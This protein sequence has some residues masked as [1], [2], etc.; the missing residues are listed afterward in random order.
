MMIYLLISVIIVLL[1]LLLLY[2]LDTQCVITLVIR[3]ITMMDPFFSIVTI[4]NELWN[5]SAI[6][7][8]WCTYTNSPSN[9]LNVI[10]H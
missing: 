10:M 6:C 2:D 1:L 3:L 4:H 9:H 5:I 8:E 7:G